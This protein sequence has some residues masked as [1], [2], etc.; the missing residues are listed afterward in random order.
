MKGY[1]TM[2][3][4]ETNRLAIMEQILTKTIRQRKA[5]EI[6]GLSIRQVIRLKKRYRKEGASGLVHQGRGRP[7]NHRLNEQLV[8]EAIKTVREKYW[9]FGPTLAWEKLKKDHGVSFSVETLR[10]AMIA[11]GI[12][13]SKRRTR[14][15]LHQMRPRRNRKGELVQIDGSPHAWLE[16]RASVCCLLVFIDDATG[17][18]LHLRL[19]PVESTDNYF[20]AVR[21]YLKTYGKPLAFYSDRHNIFRVNTNRSGSSSTADTNG[22]SQFGRAMDELGIKLICANSPQAKGRVERSNQTLQDRLVKELRLRKIDTMKKA[23]LYLPE[24]QKEFNRQFG[25]KPR[26]EEDAHRPLLPSDNLDQILIRRYQRLLSKNLE[27][28]YRNQTYQV[29]TP[30]PSYALRKAPV[31]VTESPNG[32]VRLYYHGQ[33]LSYR[34]LSMTP[35]AQIVDTKNLNL[36]VDRIMT[37]TKKPFLGALVKKKIYHPSANHPWRQTYNHTLTNY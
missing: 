13:Q 17:E 11:H 30:R 12:W 37:E 10:K 14:I 31:L 23:N 29:Q 7:S 22:L 33:K 16:N 35:E 20:E 2:S 34:V 4:K 8:T 18:L 36:C 21:T 6:L 1:L 28:Q 19:A 15:R 24:F 25:V 32:K 3:Q 26:N 9:D 5:A 27:L